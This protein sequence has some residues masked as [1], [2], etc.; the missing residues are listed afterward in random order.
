MPQELKARV[1]G[2][3]AVHDYAY[4]R[5]KIDPNLV[6]D[7][8]RRAVPP[9]RQAVVLDHGAWGKSLYLG[10]HCAAIE[11]VS[12]TEG[13]ALID[14]LMA[15]AAQERFIYSHPWRPHDMIMW[16]NRAVLHRAT[17][18][19]N[20]TER[21]HM[22]RTTVAGEG[23]TVPDAAAAVA[24]FSR[25]HRLPRGQTPAGWGAMKRPSS[26]RT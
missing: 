1:E 19:E 10:A 18:F 6:T 11:G 9:V 16:D 5:S 26:P 3:V 14:D 17:P 8:E 13:R 7:E 24:E 22:V 12:E 2:R 4:G 20:T 23:S 21:R 25:R 15:F